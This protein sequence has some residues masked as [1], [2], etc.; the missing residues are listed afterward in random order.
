MELEPSVKPPR[1]EVVL[2]LEVL[3]Q[4]PL[5][6]RVEQGHTEARAPP[7]LLTSLPSFKLC[8]AAARMQST[9]RSRPWKR[10]CRLAAEVVVTAVAAAAPAGR[11]EAPLP[12]TQALAQRSS[13]TK[14]TS[15]TFGTTF[16]KHHR[17]VCV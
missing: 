3:E 13:S 4:G 12:G 7:S 17:M 8:K 10:P 16:K 11:E 15:N 14:I 2:R 6:A 5:R 1:L 9:L